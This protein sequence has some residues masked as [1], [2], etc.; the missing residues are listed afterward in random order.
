MD[1][2]GGAAV[3][4]T[5][6]HQA[7][8]AGT[9]SLMIHHRGVFGGEN[10]PTAAYSQAGGASSSAVRNKRLYF[11]LFAPVGLELF[12]QVLMGAS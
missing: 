6:A 3:L 1:G 12:R 9:F 5:P 4:L 2:T 7:R 10:H 8:M 11:I